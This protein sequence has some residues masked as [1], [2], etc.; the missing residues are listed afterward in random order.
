[1][2]VPETC[3]LSPDYPSGRTGGAGSWAGAGTWVA[4]ALFEHCLEHQMVW[5]E[6][7]RQAGQHPVVVW[8]LSLAFGGGPWFVSALYFQVPLSGLQGTAF[9]RNC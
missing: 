4:V 2:W 6:S 5:L 1:M 9:K 8:A 7:P 3:V